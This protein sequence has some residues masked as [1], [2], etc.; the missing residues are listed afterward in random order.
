MASTT[1]FL[2]FWEALNKGDE[3]EAVRVFHHA[4]LPNGPGGAPSP[5]VASV[6]KSGEWESSQKVSLVCITE[7]ACAGAVNDDPHRFCGRYSCPA[8]F[9]GRGSKTMT[10]GWYIPVGNKTGGFFRTPWL[11]LDCDGGPIRSRAAA[12]L[13]DGI[14]PFCTRQWRRLRSEQ[15]D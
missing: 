8:V 10:P 13:T 12:M 11:P 14:N 9:H 5:R 15:L 7:G 6:I 1:P 4:A 3:D 2:A